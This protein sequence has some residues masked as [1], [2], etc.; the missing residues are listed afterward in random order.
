MKQFFFIATLLFLTIGIEA[1]ERASSPAVVN[2]V[3]GVPVFMFAEPVVEFQ[4]AEKTLSVKNMFKLASDGDETPRDKVHKLI[5][6]IRHRVEEGKITCFDAVIVDIRNDYYDAICFKGEKSLQAN[7]HTVKD[8]PI[9]FFS[10]PTEPYDTV[11]VIP[12]EYSRRAKRNFLYDKIKSM[13]GRI[14]KKEKK[15]EI[16]QFDALIYNPDDLS[17]VAIR[18]KKEE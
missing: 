16:G 15:K 17:A 8:V 6:M 18:F 1:R 14:L 10:K 3:D 5:G 7:V 11:A 13:V 4:R 12:A 2:V 9:Y